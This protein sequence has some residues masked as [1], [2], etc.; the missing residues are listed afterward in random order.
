MCWIKRWLLLAEHIFQVG[1][2]EW[3]VLFVK[4]LQTA[5]LFALYILSEWFTNKRHGVTL[6]SV[7]K[8]MPSPTFNNQGNHARY[9]IWQIYSIWVARS[10]R[11]VCSMYFASWSFYIMYNALIQNLSQSSRPMGQKVSHSS[12]CTSWNASQLSRPTGW[13]AS[14]SSGPTGLNV[15]YSSRPTS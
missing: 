3:W 1:T 13:N 12:R 14:H 9:A 5:Q 7:I 11:S 8:L 6:V 15:I 2:Y 4:S 10:P